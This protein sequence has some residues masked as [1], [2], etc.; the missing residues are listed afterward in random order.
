MVATDDETE[1]GQLYSCC[2]VYGRNVM[3]ASMLEVS[4]FRVG[5]VLRLERDAWPMAKYLRQAT[6]EYAPPHRPGHD[7][8]LR[9]LFLLALFIGHPKVGGGER[10]APGRRSEGERLRCHAAPGKYR[11]FG[12]LFRGTRKSGRSAVPPRCRC[13]MF[14]PAA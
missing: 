6:S 3:S 4:L 8:I 12:S 9:W 13:G 1:R 5:T 7:S 11:S 10:A 14:Q 2:L